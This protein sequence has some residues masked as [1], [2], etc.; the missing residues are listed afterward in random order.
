MKNTINRTMFWFRNG[1]EDLSS[2]DIKFVPLGDL[3]NRLLSESYKGPKIKF[4]N[5]Y[6]KTEENYELHPVNPKY[7]T[8][9]YNGV[10]LYNDVINLQTFKGLDFK[11]QTQFLWKRGYELLQ[12]AAIDSK[13]PELLE[14][15]KYAYE[16]GLSMNLN[17]NFKLITTEV[18][19]HNVALQA[20]ILIKYDTPK[21]YSHFILEKNGEIIFEKLIDDNR[22]D[23]EIFFDFIKKIEVKNNIIILKGQ[24]DIDYLP[25]K[26]PISED[27]VSK[28]L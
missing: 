26:I 9:W 13:N 19:L 25:M 17:P 16:K 15:C 11:M 18:V 20:A 21:M 6:L 1:Y 4:I 22:V 5:L 7:Y 10:L 12:I 8:H 14:A 24:R 23:F 3:L 27:V 2:L 28:F